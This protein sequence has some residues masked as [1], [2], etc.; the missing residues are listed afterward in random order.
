MNHEATVTYDSEPISLLDRNVARIAKNY[1]GSMCGDS[2]E[3]GKDRWYR[4]IKYSFA[5]PIRR[6][7]FIT[8]VRK[9][10]KTAAFGVE[11]TVQ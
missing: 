3:Q 4:K 10:L 2:F 9:F 6:L 8:E 7:R 1:S 5:K 11:V